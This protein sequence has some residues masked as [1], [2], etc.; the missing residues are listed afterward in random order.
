MTFVALP[1]LNVHV[2]VSG[3]P[4]AP[5]LLLLHALGASSHV[6]D[7]QAAALSDRFHVIRPDMRGHGLT[8]VTPG[9]TSMA[10]LADDALGVLDA[11]GIAVAHVAGLSIGGLV[12]QALVA[13]APSRVMSLCLC[14]TALVIPPP[15]VWRE[16]AAAVRRDGMRALIEPIMARWVTPAF[17]TAPG[18]LGLRAMLERTDPEGYAG[19][20]EAIADADFTEAAARIAVP[21]LIM[22]G[23]LDQSTPVANADALHAA[24][25]GSRLVVLPDVAHIPT[26]QAPELVS[27]ALR[28]FLSPTTG[29][30]Y[31]DGM[32]VRR[33]VLGDAH[34][35]RSLAA[36]TGLDRDFQAF[37]VRSFWGGAWTRGHFD[38]RM[39]SVVTM[40]IMAALGH[41]DEF[42][43]HV[44]A[45][46]RTGA[47]AADVVELLMQV[48]VYAGMPAANRAMRAAKE[49]FAEL[50][51]A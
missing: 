29:D 5:A 25:A 17:Q 8:Q 36:L 9:P 37:I 34:V 2:Q 10:Q 6:W 15:E 28:R 31:A 39:R 4:H 20:A 35:E 3:A 46:V 50:E 26:V 18:A 41:H 1:G 38:H 23:A 7:A 42:K 14:D 21:T 30:P 47:T 24:I 27:A 51:N 33:Q 16:R 48:A 13:R 32:A 43:L 44:L 22:V 40:A 11:L 45:T 49:A 19:A 12:A